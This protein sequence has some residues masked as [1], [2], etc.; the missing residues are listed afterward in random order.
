M[1]IN[2]TLKPTIRLF[3]FMASISVLSACKD[4]NGKDNLGD[5]IVA[6][7]VGMPSIYEN[8]RPDIK[9]NVAASFDRLKIV[10]RVQLSNKLELVAEFIPEIDNSSSVSSKIIKKSINRA[11]VVETNIPNGTLYQI[12]GYNMSKN[13]LTQ[14]RDYTVG[15]EANSPS[16]MLDGGDSY[17]MIGATSNSP[18]GPLPQ[19]VLATSN[20]NNYGDIQ[21]RSYNAANPELYI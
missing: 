5:N 1:K 14:F 10:E 17:R 4:I 9:N 19:F 3:V 2:Q 18:T 6:H 20:P 8:D 7:K 21:A 13:E 16:L 15:N 11:A 12:R